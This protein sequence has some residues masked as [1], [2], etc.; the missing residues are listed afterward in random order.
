MLEF[1]CLKVNAG[2]TKV[3]VSAVGAGEIRKVGNHH[4]GYVAQEWKNLI[5]SYAPNAECGSTNDVVMSKVD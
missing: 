2:K 4:A 5:R 3:M 1:K